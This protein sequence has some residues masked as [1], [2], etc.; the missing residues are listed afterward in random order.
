MYQPGSH[1]IS[2]PPSFCG[3]CLYFSRDKDSAIPSLVER[4]VEFC[5][6]TILSFSTRWPF[7]IIIII[8]EEKSQLPGFELT[9]RRVR[10]LRGYQL[11]YRGDRPCLRVDKTSSQ[12][13]K[14]KALIRQRA[15]NFDRDRVIFL[16]VKLAEGFGHAQLTRWD[17]RDQSGLGPQEPKINIK[18]SNRV[19]SKNGLKWRNQVQLLETKTALFL[20]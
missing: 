11:S 17:P 12:A 16:E 8:I 18:T 2:H 6:L 19:R 9:S 4:E 13:Q 7:F 3:A 1:R 10:R 15:P 5:L 20:K 14:N